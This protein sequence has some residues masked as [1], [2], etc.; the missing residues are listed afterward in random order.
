MVILALSLLLGRR[1][2]Q[3][4]QKVRIAFLLNE[5]RL[6]VKAGK[7]FWRFT[8]VEHRVDSFGIIIRFQPLL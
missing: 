2:F 6:F 3:F 7:A 1:F 8:L 4:T 5:K